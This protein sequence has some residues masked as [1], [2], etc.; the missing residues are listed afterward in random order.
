L[1]EQLAI[2]DYLCD[3]ADEHMVTELSE[4]NNHPKEAHSNPDVVLLD[5]S[6]SVSASMD[7]DP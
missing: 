7:V 6:N 4:Q 2:L 3:L 1:E 5:L